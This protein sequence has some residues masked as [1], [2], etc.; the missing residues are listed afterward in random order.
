M[1]GIVVVGS[2]NATTG[3]AT[4]WTCDIGTP[5]DRGDG[6]PRQV[7]AQTLQGAAFDARG[8]L[9]VGRSLWNGPPRVDSG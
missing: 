3:K 1:S 5:T 7:A 2:V 9:T 8:P 6:V 4:L